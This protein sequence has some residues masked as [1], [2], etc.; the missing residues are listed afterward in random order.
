MVKGM[1]CIPAV[2]VH[3]VEKCQKCGGQSCRICFETR[4]FLGLN[5][6]QARVVG[7]FMVHD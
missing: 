1:Q 4:G 6:S 2:C 3:I 7:Y 5:Y